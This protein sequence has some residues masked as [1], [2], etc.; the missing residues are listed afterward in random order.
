MAV[1]LFPADECRVRLHGPFQGRIEG[2]CAR[3]VAETM[4]NEPRGLLS[5]LKILRERR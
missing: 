4:K 2:W 1:L 3:R 5:D